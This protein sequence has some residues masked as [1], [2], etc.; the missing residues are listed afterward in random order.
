MLTINTILRRVVIGLLSVDIKSLD[1]FKSLGFD[2]HWLE[3]FHFFVL[4]FRKLYPLAWSRHSADRSEGGGGMKMCDL[5]IMQSE[6]E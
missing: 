3:A 2:L 6:S 4:T 5:Q 1:L